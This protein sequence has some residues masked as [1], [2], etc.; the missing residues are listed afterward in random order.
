[1]GLIIKKEAARR[2]GRSIRTI[3]EW[4][5]QGV[6]NTHLVKQTNYIDGDTVDA[7]K[8]TEADVTH[9]IQ[10]RQKIIEGIEK[11]I[12]AFRQREN[13]DKWPVREAVITFVAV[14]DVLADREKKVLIDVM[15]GCPY[16]DIGEGL[17]LTRERVR[18]IFLKSLRRISAS[19]VSYRQMLNETIELRRLRDEVREK[20]RELRRLRKMLNVPEQNSEECKLKN[21]KLVDMELSV[22]AL[23]CLKSAQIY[24]IGDLLEYDRMDLLKFRNFGNKSLNELDDLLTRLGLKWGTGK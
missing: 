21:I 2:L 13:F 15:E 8:D 22:R 14:L 6:L 9:A 24:T 19:M 23:N 12:M 4:I 17:G 10:E 5:S 7:L 3:N 1:M 20:D 18:Q 16:E 11:E